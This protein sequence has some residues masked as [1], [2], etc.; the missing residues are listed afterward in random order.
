MLPIG[1]RAAHW[2][3]RLTLLSMNW[4]LNRFG[5]IGFP[6]SFMITFQHHHQH[7]PILMG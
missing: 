1:L 5:E 4:N 6:F 3:Q 7:L 2:E